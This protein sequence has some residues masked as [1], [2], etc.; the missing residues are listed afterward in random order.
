[1]RINNKELKNNLVFAPMAGVSDVGMR[2]LCSYY[3]ADATFTEMLSAMAMEHNSSKNRLLT[4]TTDAEKIKVAQIFGKSPEIMAKVVNDESL[5]KFDAIDINMGCPAPKIIKNGEGSALMKNPLLA[6]KI[7]KSCVNSS[8]KPVSVK[9]RLGFDKIVATD[10]AKMCEDSGASFIT[11]HGRTQSQLFSGSVN[12]EEIAKVKSAV[13]IPVIGN[14][15]V[16]DRESYLKMLGTGVDAVMVGRGAQGKPWI[17]SVLQGKELKINPYEVAKKH[18]EILRNYFDEK[19]LKLYMRK[20]FLWYLSGVKCANENR[21]KIATSNDIEKSLA[22]LKSI[23]C[24]ND[25]ENN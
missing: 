25:F 8:K 3:G 23:F 5:E 15:D 20:H 24:D 1:M 22:V 19:W 6:S 11:V 9:M 21:I 12:Y 4:L 7:I 10:F 17:F 18:V 16:V 13:K 14:G 2:F